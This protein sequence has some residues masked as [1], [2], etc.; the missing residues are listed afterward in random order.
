MTE[1]FLQQIRSFRRRSLLSL[2]FQYPGQANL[3]DTAALD[4]RKLG[5][6]R[7]RKGMGGVL[8][9]VGVHRCQLQVAHSHLAP[10]ERRQ[11]IGRILASDFV[12]D[13]NCLSVAVQCIGRAQHRPGTADVSVRQRVVSFR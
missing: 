3:G 1:R 9:V 6:E 10:G 11:R 2:P 12:V 5:F 7:V 13:A 4:I 8:V